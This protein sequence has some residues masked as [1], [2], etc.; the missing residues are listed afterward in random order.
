MAEVELET[1][2]RKGCGEPEGQ[3]YRMTRNCIVA[4][5]V[6]ITSGG[7]Y[8]VE[9]VAHQV[10]A[11]DEPA[12]LLVVMEAEDGVSQGRARRPREARGPSPEVLRRA[13]GAGL[14][15]CE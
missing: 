9:V 2:G 4:V 12:R 6:R 10:R 5:P 7:D 14:P 3:F 11:G 8:R 15:G 13:C 1:L